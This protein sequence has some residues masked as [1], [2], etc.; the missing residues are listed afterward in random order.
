M[1][2]GKMDVLDLLI[3]VLREH[4]KDMDR[5]LERLEEHDR[6]LER[7][8]YGFALKKEEEEKHETQ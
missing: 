7:I 5:I 4:E 2:T 3:T 1:L 6:D 8:C